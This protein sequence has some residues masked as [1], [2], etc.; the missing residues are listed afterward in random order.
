[1]T[2][3]VPDATSASPFDYAG[4]VFIGAELDPLSYRSAT[5]LDRYAS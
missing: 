1:M 3:T 5:D 2:V 4:R